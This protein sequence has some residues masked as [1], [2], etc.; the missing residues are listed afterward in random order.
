MG[1]STAAEAV[2]DIQSMS[3]GTGTESG[4][5]GPHKAALTE[6]RGTHTGNTQTIIRLA[7]LLLRCQTSRRI[8]EKSANRISIQN[9]NTATITVL[10]RFT[11][12][13]QLLMNRYG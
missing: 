8:M 12:A 10:M 13:L 9:G 3:Q 5:E 1:E 7:R 6:G 4:P 11:G 2:N